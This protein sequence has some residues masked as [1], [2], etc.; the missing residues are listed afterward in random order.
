MGLCEKARSV[1]DEEC[2]LVA[3]MLDTKQ[4]LAGQSGVLPGKRKTSHGTVDSIRQ[5][6]GLQRQRLFELRLI[7]SL[8]K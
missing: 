6:F 8:W 7:R 3:E 4:R 5:A 2:P 1:A